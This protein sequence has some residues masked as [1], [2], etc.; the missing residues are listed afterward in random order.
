MSRIR[1]ALSKFV[2][3]FE[4]HVTP[5]NI[6]ESW[7]NV[8]IIVESSTAHLQT[9]WRIMTCIDATPAVVK[10]AAS[11]NCNLIVA[12]HP[13]MFN[14]VKR[15]TQRVS[16]NVI[17]ALE[18]G[19]SLFSPHT[20]LD[21]MEG[22]HN[23]FLC[24]MFKHLES[25]RVGCS[26]R[27]DS[28]GTVKVGRITRFASP[29][30]FE[31][32]LNTIKEFFG[33]PTVRVAMSP[34][35]SLQDPVASVAV[36]VGSG[37]FVLNDSGADVYLTGE[38]PHHDLVKARNDNVKA[39]LLEHCASERPFLRVLNQKLAVIPGVVSVEQAE[40]DVSPIVCL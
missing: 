9:E 29:V 11:K 5:L 7:D 17:S 4:A 22:G 14:N 35:S 33:V 1:G 12:Y 19:I 39:V 10:E 25:E 32:V 27:T 28:S 2:K 36:C 21:S 8:G 38:M 6:A 24:D 16:R 31:V 37:S 34:E 3:D 23:D 40:S 18:N 30:P 26:T 20:S 15:L 13:P